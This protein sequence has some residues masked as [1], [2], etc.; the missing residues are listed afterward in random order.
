M[1]FYVLFSHASRL[2]LKMRPLI[3]RFFSFSRKQSIS[4]KKKSGLGLCLAICGFGSGRDSEGGASYTKNPSAAGLD[5][6]DIFWK[7]KSIEKKGEEGG[8]QDLY[9]DFCVTYKRWEGRETK[10]RY[11]DSFFFPG[12]YFFPLFSSVFQPECQN[13]LGSTEKKRGRGKNI[14]KARHTTRTYVLC[15]MPPRSFSLSQKKWACFV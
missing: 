15:T 9:L 2:P 7:K 13:A 14:F 3:W 1:L 12:Y 6:P 8:E 11:H 5:S 10:S 4:Q